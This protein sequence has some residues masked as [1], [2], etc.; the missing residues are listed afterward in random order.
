V[1]LFTNDFFCFRFCFGDPDQ[2]FLQLHTVRGFIL[3]FPPPTPRKYRETYAKSQEAGNDFIDPKYR[4]S[5][6]PENRNEESEQVEK[7]GK[8]K[9]NKNK[10]DQKNHI[11]KRAGRPD[12]NS[13]V[14]NLPPAICFLLHHAN[15]SRLLHYADISGRSLRKYFNRLF[16]LAAKGMYILVYYK[17]DSKLYQE[18]CIPCGIIGAALFYYSK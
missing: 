3:Q 11:F 6:F 17:E 16:A 2:F 12:R 10:R 15:S 4:L 18:L 9:N 5:V 7:I 1:K 14:F 13:R 8:R